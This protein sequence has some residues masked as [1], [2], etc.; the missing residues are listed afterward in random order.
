MNEEIDIKEAVDNMWSK[1]A[2][3][4]STVAEDTDDFAVEDAKEH[5]YIK[6]KK[7]EGVCGGRYKSQFLVNRHSSK[8]IMTTIK[9]IWRYMGKSGSSTKQVKVYPG[10]EKELGCTGW[11]NPTGADTTYSRQIVAAW[12][13]T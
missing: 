5:V 11:A 9:T 2:E 12:F 7:V 4:W 6:T 3:S 8:T 1:E 10:D 13:V